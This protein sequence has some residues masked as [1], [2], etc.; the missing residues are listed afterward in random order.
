[1]NENTP[2]NKAFSKSILLIDGDCV[3]C[4]KS[5]LWLEKNCLTNNLYYCALQSTTGKSLAKKYQFE[6]IQQQL[7]GVVLIQHEKFLTGFSAI[8][9]L[10]D[11]FKSFPKFILL[12]LS[13]LPDRLLNKVY[14]T[15]AKYRYK[16]FGKKESCGL[17]SPSVQ[18]R[19][20]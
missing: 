5:V 14:S 10:K 18:D 17:L 16:W 11:R 1:M 20:L 7:S 15:T 19:V 13:L 4:N 3:L 9:G 12:T 2:K 6:N 8:L